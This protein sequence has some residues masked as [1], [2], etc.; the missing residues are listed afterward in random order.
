V[1]LEGAKAGAL[2]RTPADVTQTV[3]I[4]LGSSYVNSFNEFGRHW[5][6]TLQA[7]GHFRSRISDINL[8]QVR[9]RWGMMVP[10]G[11]V[12]SVREITGP[13]FIN[14]YNLYTAAPVTGSLR[15]G[16][17]SGDVIAEVDRRAVETLPR[18]MKADWTD[19]MFLQI[20]RGNTTP[21]PV[22]F[23]LSG[24]FVFLALAGLY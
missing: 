15:P 8:L 21:P 17:S 16:A 4:F 1:E 13:I 18:S 23:G 10:L 3:E 22:V 24:L 5:Q 11:T 19:L 2:G 9:N 20:L 14:R 7:E 12:V 6:V